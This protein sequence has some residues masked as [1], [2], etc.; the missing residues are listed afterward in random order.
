T[1]KIDPW[2]TG[3]AG[4]LN[5][6]S[7]KS[8]VTSPRLAVGTCAQPANEVANRIAPTRSTRMKVFTFASAAGLYP[9][10]GHSMACCTVILHWRDRGRIQNKAR[11]GVGNQGR[12]LT[13]IPLVPIGESP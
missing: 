9:L 7:R 2:S 11:Q 3:S 4:G 10:G 5:S 1:A 8:G 13:F 6:A 12:M